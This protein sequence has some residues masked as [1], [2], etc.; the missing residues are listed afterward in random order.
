MEWPWQRVTV[1]ER[2]SGCDD[3]IMLLKIYATIKT[4][5]FIPTIPVMSG[6]IWHSDNNEAAALCE[7]L[8]FFSCYCEKVINLNPLF[9]FCAVSQSLI[10]VCPFKH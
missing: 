3:E 9:C 10:T 6:M 4:T 2:S 1:S 5:Q 8:H 7:I